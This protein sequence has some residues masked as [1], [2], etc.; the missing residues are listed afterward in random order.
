MIR[1][2]ISGLGGHP[3]ITLPDARRHAQRVPTRPPPFSPAPAAQRWGL[4]SSV[5]RTFKLLTLC[6]KPRVRP[7]DSVA[8]PLSPH[9]LPSSPEFLC[10]EAH[11]VPRSCKTPVSDVEQF[12]S[13]RGVEPVGVGEHAHTAPGIEALLSFFPVFGGKQWRPGTHRRNEIVQPGGRAG[14]I[15]VDESNRDPRAKDDVLRGDIVV[16]DNVRG[17]E[18]QRDTGNVERRWPLYPGRQAESRRTI[19]QTPQQC[20][21]TSQDVFIEHPVLQRPAWRHAIYKGQH[22]S[23]LLVD[24]EKPRGTIKSGILKI[25]EKGMHRSAVRANRPPDG[26]AHSNDSSRNVPSC[27]GLFSSL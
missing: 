7:L 10:S 12:R 26:V 3:G 5:Q 17:V 23:P 20:R 14:K 4:I 11:G 9:T 16:P 19:M 13:F 18:R 8:Y 15:E 6:M 1:L 25:F 21:D 24:A 27:Q 22:L 2:G